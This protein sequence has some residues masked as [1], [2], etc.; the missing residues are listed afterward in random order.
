[1]SCILSNVPGYIRDADPSNFRVV[2][3]AVQVAC[4]CHFCDDKSVIIH[5]VYMISSSARLLILA[6]LVR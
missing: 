5:S 2:S 3:E 1:M 4:F 6:H